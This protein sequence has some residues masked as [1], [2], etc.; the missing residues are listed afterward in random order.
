[1]SLD[2]MSVWELAKH[3]AELVAAHGLVEAGK[4]PAQRG[5]QMAIGWLH[6]HLNAADQPAVT[7]VANDPADEPAR[8]ALTMRVN[9]LLQAH[10]GLVP[11]LRALLKEIAAESGA[12]TQTVGDN[13]AAIQNR[14]SNNTNTITR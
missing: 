3:L 12:M 1:M 9:D 2:L 8:Y 7:A 10:P 11:D 14:G 5:A 4:H 13:S 6:K